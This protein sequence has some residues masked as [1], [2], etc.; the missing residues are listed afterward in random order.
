MSPIRKTVSICLVLVFC[1]ASLTLAADRIQKKD[2]KKDGSCKTILVD[3]IVPTVLAADQTRTRTRK[4][5]KDGS[6]QTAPSEVTPSTI[7]AADQIRTKKK[8]KDGSCRL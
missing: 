2:Q 4:Q 7:L 3:P 6:C 5:L 8:L 1:S